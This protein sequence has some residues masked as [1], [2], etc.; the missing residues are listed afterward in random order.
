MCVYR[1]PWSILNIAVSI[2]LRIFA[3][4]VTLPLSQWSGSVTLHRCPGIHTLSPG[5]YCKFLLI[6]GC[7]LD[8]LLELCATYSPRLLVTTALLPTPLHDDLQVHPCGHRWQI[9]PF[10]AGLYST[11]YMIHVFLICLLASGHFYSFRCCKGWS[12]SPQTSIV[13]LGCALS[14]PV[15]LS[16]LSF[17][18]SIPPSLSSIFRGVESMTSRIPKQASVK[19]LTSLFTVTLL[20]HRLTVCEGSS[21]RPLPEMPSSLW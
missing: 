9:P 2:E 14:D 16:L 17:P 10:R 3:F 12:N 21:A 4:P 13:H 7:N 8:P 11:A 20:S 5:S 1:I 19:L 15:S 6:L 18:P